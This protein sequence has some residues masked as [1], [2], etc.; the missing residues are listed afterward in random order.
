MVRFVPKPR[1]Q[2][3]EKK[4]KKQTISLKKAMDKFDKWIEIAKLDAKPHQR[5]GVKWCLTKELGDKPIQ[6][7]RGGL[8]ADEMGLGKTY[9][10]IGMIMSNFMKRTL[11]VLPVSLIDQWFRHIK[12]TTGHDALVYHGAKRSQI[13][14]ERVKTAPIVITSYGTVAGGATLMHHFRWSRVLFDEA[15]HLR[16]EKTTRYAGALQIRAKIRWLI[17]GTPIQNRRSDFFALCK[18]MGLRESYYSH[19]KN[20]R[21]LAKNF[22]LKRT[23]KQVGIH[24]PTKHEHVI[25]V[26]WK[27]RKERQ[28]A[29]DL[30]A[31]LSFT[32]TF[33]NGRKV[34]KAV[35]SMGNYKLPIM[36]RARQTCVMPRLLNKCVRSKNPGLF[37]GEQEDEETFAAAMG[38]SSKMDAVVDLIKSRKDNGRPKLIFCHFRGEI[39]AVSDRLKQ[40]GM[41]VGQFDGRTSQNEREEILMANTDAL[42][43]QIQTGCE[44]L[45]LQQ[46]KEVYFVSPTWNPA[47]EDQAVAR[48]HRIGQTKP[49]DVFRFVMEGFGQKSITLDSHVQSIQSF[50]RQEADLLDETSKETEKIQEP[51]SQLSPNAQLPE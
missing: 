50:K 9:T 49:V 31:A 34:N 18:M 41:T 15:H 4:S 20:L 43:L 39:D 19:Q 1:T 8:V 13:S 11:I 5:A 29:E 35:E 40:L 42:I 6:G 45:N 47:I 7:V 30:H 37:D 44:G 24:L 28:L 51:N 27:S 36:L 10:M 38:S 14:Y 32:G 17:T 22:L 12:I 2:S 23:K 25:L 48:S 16:N 33:T 46:F 21:E 26:K 3:G